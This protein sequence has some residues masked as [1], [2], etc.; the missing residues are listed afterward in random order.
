MEDYYKLTTQYSCIRLQIRKFSCLIC[1][2]R[3]FRIHMRWHQ[4]S[5]AVVIVNYC[6][7]RSLRVDTFTNCHLLFTCH[8]YSTSLKWQC[9]LKIL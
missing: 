8:C 3:F 2:F 1:H 6:D 5:N 9:N 4:F 7:N